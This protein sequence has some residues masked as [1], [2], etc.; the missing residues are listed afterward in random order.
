MK[1]LGHVS[2]AVL[3][4]TSCTQA[5]VDICV[6]YGYCMTLNI[7]HNAAVVGACPKNP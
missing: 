3:Y 1:H 2:V 5:E 4:I 6:L 7:E